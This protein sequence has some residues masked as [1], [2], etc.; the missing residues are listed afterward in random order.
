MIIAFIA[1][2]DSRC[3]NTPVCGKFQATKLFTNQLAKILETA[4]DSW[5][6]EQ[7]P[8]T[9]QGIV[10]C[11]REGSNQLWCFTQMKIIFRVL[12]TSCLTLG[13]PFD[14]YE[15]QFPHLCNA[16]DTHLKKGY[17]RI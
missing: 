11:L 1:F 15:P 3:V 10:S 9:P 7:A 8:R 16:D 13:K 6:S 4:V 17:K 5:E 2:A 14:F 12:F